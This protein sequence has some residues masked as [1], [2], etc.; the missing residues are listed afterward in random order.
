METIRV[1][2]NT[3][4]ASG[5]CEKTEFT[6]ESTTD[7]K[8]LQKLHNTFSEDNP[9]SFVHFYWGEGSFILGIKWNSKI[10]EELYN[11][12]KI[13]WEEYCNRTK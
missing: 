13:S 3:F 12:G 10:A 5:V 8:T 2:I 7:D 11:A 9:D 6:I 1:E 4:N